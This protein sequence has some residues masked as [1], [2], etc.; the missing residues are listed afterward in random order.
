MLLMHTAALSALRKELIDSVGIDQA[1]GFSPDGLRLGRPTRSSPI[2]CGRSEKEPSPA[3]SR[4]TCLRAR[5]RRSGR[6][7]G[8]ERTLRGRVPVGQLLEAEVLSGNTGQ[9]RDPVCWMQIGYASG[10]TG[11]HGTLHPVQ[12]GRLQR[13]HGLRSVP[14]RRQARR[15]VARM[16]PPT[17]WPPYYRRTPS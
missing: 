17:N 10:Y 15:K 8:P 3:P 14:H 16:P 6:R 13:H 7:D 11:L 1:R 4:C 5:D 12:G 9:T 2:R